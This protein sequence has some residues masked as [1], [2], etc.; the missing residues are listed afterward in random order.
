MESLKLNNLNRRDALKKIGLG[1]GAS[2]LPGSLISGCF[3][4]TSEPLVL[5]SDLKDPIYYSSALAIATAIKSK[6]ISSEEVT[7][8]FLKRIKQ[9]NPKINA[10][11]QLVGDQA[12][13]SARKADKALANVD[14]LG[15][16]HGVPMTIKDS[17]DTKGIISTAGTLGRANYVPD[18]DA[19]IVAKLKNA[20]A[21]LLGKTNTP[22]LTIHGDTRNL[23]YGPTKNPY[24]LNHSPGGSSGGPAAIVSAGGSAFDIGSDTGGSVRGPSHCCGICGIKPTSGRVS[25]SGHI[26]SFDDYKQSLTTVGPMCRYVEDLIM[27][28][29]IISGSDGIDPYIYDIP[30]GSLNKTEISDLNFVY[31]TDNGIKTPVPEIIQ[32]IHKVATKLSNHGCQIEESRPIEVEETLELFFEL[33]NADSRYSLHQILAKSGTSQVSDYLEWV[34]ESVGEFETKSISPKQFA[35]IFEKWSRFK[36]KMTSFFSKYDILLCPVNATAAPVSG[37][38]SEEIKL[39]HVSYN[40]TYNLTGWPVA[41]VRIGTSANDLPL[42]IQIVGKPWQEGKI[43]A[44]AKF[45]EQE[46]GGFQLPGI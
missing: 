37:V 17:F 27:I 35:K 19:T 11:V 24:N 44:V 23:I 10:V 14:E 7:N 32:S 12:L 42:G 16:L 40:A 38:T 45:L 20:G 36:S 28:L 15:P 31:Y 13:E 25:R 5:V 9:I 39:N 33:V 2:V 43:L 21:I 18:R 6:K 1:V 8:I 34:N 30:F 46:F 26:I 29:P 22:E 41:V 3:I 4:E